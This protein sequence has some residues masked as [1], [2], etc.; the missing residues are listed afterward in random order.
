MTTRTSQARPYEPYI[1][2]TPNEIIFVEARP[3]VSADEIAYYAADGTP[4][5]RWN[6]LLA[7]PLGVVLGLA[8]WG[9]GVIAFSLAK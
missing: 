5:M 2:V 1:A 6:H 4:R 3:P 7:I 8:L 9:L